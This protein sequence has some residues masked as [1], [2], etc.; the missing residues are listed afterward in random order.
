MNTDIASWRRA[1]R[2][3]TLLLSS[4][5][6]TL[7]LALVLWFMNLATGWES[8]TLFWLGGA[9]ATFVLGVCLR[10]RWKD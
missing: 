2:L 9:T 1:I 4:Y 10:N 8:V 6:T 3:F 5:G 7:V